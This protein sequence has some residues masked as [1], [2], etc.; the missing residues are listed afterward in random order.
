MNCNFHKILFWVIKS[1]RIRPT[2]YVTH[3]VDIIIWREILQGRATLETRG[4]DV[5]SNDLENI[6]VC[7]C[8]LQV[9]GQ[10]DSTREYNY[11][12]N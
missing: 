3:V 6:K 2:A 8:C 9:D 4:C 10:L 7:S 12:T 11:W 1:K 5:E